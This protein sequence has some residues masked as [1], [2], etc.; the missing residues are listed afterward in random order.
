MRVFE[1]NLVDV[2]DA[3]DRGRPGRH[4]L[5]TPAHIP[6]TEKQEKH[7]QNRTEGSTGHAVAGHRGTDAR[8]DMC[9][10]VERVAGR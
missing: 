7:S 6:E 9:G 3:P 8:T 4:S 10:E 1:R 5:W 2:A